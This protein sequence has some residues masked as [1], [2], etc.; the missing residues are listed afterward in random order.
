MQP[1]TA[2]KRQELERLWRR[3]VGI[4]GEKVLTKDGFI[5]NFSDAL[6]EA[7]L[8][9]NSFGS[10]SRWHRRGHSYIQFRSVLFTGEVRKLP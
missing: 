2:Q 3:V 8:G 4:G 10:M 7:D 1:V 6:S 9:K 5:L